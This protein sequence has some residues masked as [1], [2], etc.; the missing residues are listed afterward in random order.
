MNR[1]KYLSAVRFFLLVIL[2]IASVAG[3]AR[4]AGYD[5]GADLTSLSL[6][7]LMDLP[8]RSVG[9]FDISSDRAP[10]SLWILGR[11]DIKTA[12]ALSISE[13]LQVSVP[14]V[15]ISPHSI[16]G[17]L[18]ASRGVPMF[19]NSTTQFMWD[20][21]NLNSGGSLGVNSGL[22]L[23]LTGDIRQIEVSSGP[24]A[25]IHGNGAINGFVNLVPKS[26]AT[27]PG[28]HFESG[29]GLDDG[30]TRMAAGQGIE[31]GP[32][33]NIY[34]YAGLA[35]SG[36]FSARDDMGYAKYQGVGITQG[37]IP[38]DY[39]VHEISWP[40]Y[41]TSLNWNHGNF[42][43]LGLLQ[44]E[45]YSADSFYINNSESPHLYNE[46]LAVRPKITI[47]FGSHESLEMNMP[48]EF[49]DTGYVSNFKQYSERGNSDLRA[50]MNTIFKTTR[51]S[52]NQI[53]CGFKVEHDHY[54]SNRYYFRSRPSFY[55]IGDDADWR[56]YSLFAEDVV[57]LGRDVTITAG[58]RYDSIKYDLDNASELL[59]ST[60]DDS[61]VFSPRFSVSYNLTD[62]T[63]IKAAYQEGFHFPPVTEIYTSNLKPETMKSF[64]A[65]FIH[66]FKNTGI[67]LTCNAFYNIFADSLL[68]DLGSTKENQRNDFGSTGG[69]IGLEWKD[70]SISKAFLSYSY[71]R[72]LDI[73]SSPV[74][75]YTADEGLNEW[76]CYP[77]H[78]IKFRFY[79]Y[80][81][82]KRLMA[83]LGF[84]YGSSVAKPDESWYEPRALF[85]NDR[86]S[87]G[88]K[89]AMRLSDNLYLDL[90]V[91]NVAHNGIPVPTYVYNNPWE[92]SL[93]ATSTC[94]YIGLRL[95]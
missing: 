38:G 7:E 64:E 88:F 44:R 30:M 41:R 94:S 18:Y 22:R 36:G 25:V 74:S 68:S 16:Y 70:G 90:L 51:I 46:T 43:M 69:E 65:G 71:S 21:M 27:D 32:D 39:K 61:D 48:C 86:F 4:A 50:E 28:I 75:I 3:G 83:S 34:I 54:R 33:K 9:F 56:L 35:G 79:R 57:S 85:E 26:G 29:Y 84:E 15:S 14:G 11:E 95:E 31:Y 20:G 77:A 55:I 60:S 19:D 6:E 80:F 2:Q 58:L 47:P 93:G 24:S 59:E 62:L 76:Y 89:G 10:G 13:I 49:F 53:A 12:P 5:K 82:E 45:Y 42:Q 72:P 87:I 81:M 67:K 23:P 8:V 63:I 1:I 91:K 78:M 73:S 66:N 17:S 40:N 52:G 92:G 37:E